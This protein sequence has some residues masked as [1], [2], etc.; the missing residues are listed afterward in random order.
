MRHRL[1][2]RI[3]R[4]RTFPGQT[5]PGYS[6]RVLACAMLLLL[7][8]LSGCGGGHITFIYPDEA[9][10]LALV[11]SRTPTIYID[12]VTDMRP[13]AQREG[14]GH[15]FKITFPN[16]PSWEAPATQIYAEAL[17]QDLEQTGLV[18]LVPLAAQADYLLSADLLSF[19]CQLQRSPTSYLITGLI[20]GAL[21][22]ALGGDSSEKAKLGVAL[23]VV[24][25]MAIP[26]PTNHR[27][28][29][30]VR[31]T[32]RDSRG[33]IVWQKACLGEITDR[34]SITPTARPDQELVN[35]DLTRAVKRAN[36]CLVG[37]LR[38]VMG[39]R[40]AAADSTAGR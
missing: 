9:M 32:L 8:A 26:V 39:D 38:Q 12:A 18:E 30:E 6:R 19:T 3:L 23:A 2:G 28:E 21:G 29:A 1:R 10:D 33:E 11:G 27:A 34:S 7:T 15:F 5:S 17:A 14:E 20:G 22:V 16:D 4:D 37:Q 36:A 25:I 31:L 35:R 13:L 40:A 24:G